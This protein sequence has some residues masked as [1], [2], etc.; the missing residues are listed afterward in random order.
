MIVVMDIKSVRME[1][2]VHA[3][4][5]RRAHWKQ[6]LSDVIRDLLDAVEGRKTK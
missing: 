2:D 3:R 4:L 1:D 5:A 6:P